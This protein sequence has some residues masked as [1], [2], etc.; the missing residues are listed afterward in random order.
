MLRRGAGERQAAPIWYIDVSMPHDLTT[1][2]IA[3][4]DL[5]RG[6]FRI[7][8]A[9]PSVATME[10]GQ[11][12]MVGIPG[13]ATLLRRP[14]SVCGLPGTFDD[15]APGAYSVLY[16]V[17]GQGTGLLGA[18]AAGAP[19][20]VLGPLGHGFSAVEEDVEPIF[21]AG[22]IGSA[23]FPALARAFA[24]RPVRMIYGARTSD[25]LPLLDWF[26]EHCPGGVT[27]TTDD[28]SAGLQGRVTDPLAELLAEPGKRKLYVCG[29]D[30]ML[31]AVA[32]LAT[33]HDVPC[34]LAMEAHMACGFGVCL[35]C[36]VPVK[37]E[38]GGIDYQRLCVE[39]PVMPAAEIAWR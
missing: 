28:G 13:S 24:G 21:V 8:F 27:V 17:V 10:P 11:F 34:E 38:S 4:H 37:N 30:P 7:D 12:F 1:D 5:G 25:D 9:A 23:P 32:A 36:V 16:K 2:V 18:L 33:R 29:P 26:R 3:N 14:Y 31:E 19:L 15:A 35:G 20:T 6:H 22:G 39:G